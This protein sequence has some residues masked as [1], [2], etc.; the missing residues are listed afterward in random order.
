L[1]PAQDIVDLIDNS[2]CGDFQDWFLADGHQALG[3][4]KDPADDDDE[5][6]PMDPFLGVS[7]ECV[8]TFLGVS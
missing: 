5:T 2:F 1:T 4:E 6:P 3:I 7:S 8:E